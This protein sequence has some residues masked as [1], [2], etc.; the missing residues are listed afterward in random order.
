MLT[1]DATGHHDG[2][3]K[4]CVPT[5]LVEPIVDK[6]I[7]TSFTGNVEVHEIRYADDSTTYEI[8]LIDT[9]GKW[10]IVDCNSC[11]SALALMGAY[12]IATF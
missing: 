10:R 11:I 7:K 12:E 5:E 2:H 4:L 1:V 6:T 8:H 3:D 9:L